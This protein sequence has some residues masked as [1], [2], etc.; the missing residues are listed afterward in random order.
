[1]YYHLK[2]NNELRRRRL[3]ESLEEKS[4]LIPTHKKATLL[5][6]MIVKK[7]CSIHKMIEDKFIYF[8]SFSAM[9]SQRHVR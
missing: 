6:K 9:A 4:R 1:M 3:S 2:F 7:Y 8:W 5:T